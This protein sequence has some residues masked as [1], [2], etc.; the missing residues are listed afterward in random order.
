L[1]LE[2]EKIHACILYHGHEYED[3]E[4]CPIVDSIDSIVEKT[5]AMLRTIIEIEEKVGLERCFDTF[6]SFFI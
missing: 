5:A 6:L 1:G 3:L 2:V 4:K